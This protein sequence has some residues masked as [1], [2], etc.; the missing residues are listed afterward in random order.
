MMSDDELVAILDRVER[1]DALTQQYYIDSWQEQDRAEGIQISHF[2]FL[3]WPGLSAPDNNQRWEHMAETIRNALAPLEVGHFGLHLCPADDRVA[4]TRQ[5]TFRTVA[6]ITGEALSSVYAAML[7]SQQELYLE[8]F[9]V[10][11]HQLGL[12]MVDTRQGGRGAPFGTK[13]IPKRLKGKGLA[14]HPELHKHP[15][16]TALHTHCGPRALLL[17]RDTDKYRKRFLTWVEDAEELGRRMVLEDGKMKLSDLPLL[18]EMDEW[19]DWRVVIF[20][21]FHTAEYGHQGEN[22][23]WPENLSREEQDDKTVYLFLDEEEGHYWWI[24]YINRFLQHKYLR[25]YRMCLACFKTCHTHQFETHECQSRGLAIHQCFTCRHIFNSK[26][27]LTAHLSLKRPYPPCEFC[28]K[29]E[30]NGEDCERDHRTANCESRD[31][32]PNGVVKIHCPDCDRTHRADMIHNCLDWGQCTN[33]KEEFSDRESKRTHRCYMQKGTRFWNPIEMNEEKGTIKKVTMHWFYDFETTRAEK[34]SENTYR[35]APMAWCVE[36]M[37]PD[38]ETRNYMLAYDVVHLI[39]EEIGHVDFQFKEVTTESDDGNRFHVRILGKQLEHFLY[40]VETVLVKRSRKDAAWKPILWAHNGSKFDV[41]FIFDYYVN[42]KHLDLAGVTYDKRQRVPTKEGDGFKWK[43]ETVHLRKRNVVRISNVGSKILQLKVMGATFCCSHAHHATALRNLPDIFGLPVSVQKGEFPYKRLKTTAWESVNEG[44]PGLVEYEIDAM[45]AKRRTA[46]IKWWLEEEMKMNVSREVI[47]AELALAGVD[48][49]F[50]PDDYHPDGPVGIWSFDTEVWKYLKADVSVGAR[51]M[52]AY[53]QKALE[54]HQKIWADHPDQAGKL[55]SPLDFS[56]SPSWAF[57]LYITWFMP[58]NLLAILTKSEATF[59]RSSLRGGR[60]DKRANYVE[61]LPERRR[62]GDKIGYYDFKS[63]YPSVQKCEVHGTHFPV[64]APEWITWSGETDNNELKRRMGDKTG[65][66]RVDTKCLKYVTHPTLHCLISGDPE[67]GNAEGGD[68]EAGGSEVSEDKKTKKLVF[69]NI[70]QTKQIYA[71]PE[72]LEAME[73]G[74]VEVTYVYEGLLF[75]KGDDVFSAYVD[76]FF[77]LKELAEKKGEENPGLRALAKLLLNSLWGKLGQRSY[78]TREWV[79][80]KDR[81]DH[82]LKEFDKGTL[83]LVKFVNAE[84]D[85]VW[86]EYRVVEDYNNRNT[87]APQI[88]AFVSMWGRV[89]LHNKV[90]RKHGQRV[91]YSDTDSAIIYIR[92]GEAV[93]HV[94]NALGD[95]TDE[96]PKIIKDAGYDLK[97]YTD[98]YISEAVLVAPKTYALKIVNEAPPLVYTKVVCK[99]FEPS[100]SNSKAI[101]FQA[102]KS[103]VWTANGLSETVG[104]KRGLSAEERGM[105]AL[106]RITDNGRLYFK[107]FLSTNEV[108]PVERHQVKSLSGTYT[109]GKTLEVDHHLVR[110]FGL[111]YPNVWTFLDFRNMGHFE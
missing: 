31:V 44:M 93:E 56:T 48:D 94:G 69:A 83:D 98:P 59:V 6:G 2:R 63:L 10:E 20:K 14:T 5:R 22:W 97:V 39:R 103:L 87:T 60:T 38:E 36:L 57:A 106:K 67:R 47:E 84:P 111:T 50:L 26:E 104:Q 72:L 3:A 109:K 35:H 89:M 45:P 96:V 1:V 91:L 49:V 65:F 4:H 108:A 74:E 33:C 62:K 77:A 28:G 88:A 76:F 51:C 80:A 64:K 7:H 13:S 82:L 34:L 54:L 19:K 107:S 11:V 95:L 41:K 90:L 9:R 27:S 92:E 18:M 110:P 86:F 105:P 29:I 100:Y 24:Q 79:S 102:M 73:S 58:E 53:H 55:V 78:N 99:G 85:R 25:Q 46:V 70:D 8:G 66:L 21:R 61:V 101:N 42:V 71:W 75:D 15:N 32:L 37:V 12:Q 40:V 43:E 81:L 16:L 52:E 68:G 17:A 23:S 30:F